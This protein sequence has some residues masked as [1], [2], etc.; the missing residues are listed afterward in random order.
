LLGGAGSGKAAR[1]S[2]LGQTL[3]SE[4]ADRLR[5]DW[6]DS[7][8]V[9]A[10]VILQQVNLA[11]PTAPCRQGGPGS[12]H[13]CQVRAGIR[14]CGILP[15]VR[16]TNFFRKV[17]PRPV[18]DAL[19]P[20]L[21]LYRE[22][23]LEAQRAQAVEA[24]TPLRQGTQGQTYEPVLWDETPSAAIRPRMCEV[25]P[26]SAEFQRILNQR[27]YYS[28]E[29]KPGLYTRGDE[30]V[31]V[32]C[33][34][35][36]LARM[37]PLGL[38]ACDIGTM[39]GMIPVLLKRRG[40]RSVVALDA[41][42]HTEK[43]RLVQL[44]TGENFDYVPRNS[45]ARIKEVLSERARLSSYYGDEWNQTKIQTGFDVVVLSG[46]LYHTISP[47]HV[48]GLAR[49]L[50]KRGGMLFLETAASC[51]D[52]YTQNWV[53][54]G[55]K[56]IYPGGSNTWFPT[57]KLLDHF[58]R[59][60]K[61]KPID[62]VHGPI[63]DGIVRIAVSAVSVADPLPLERESEWFMQTTTNT[64]DYREIVDTEWSQGSSVEIPYSPGKCVY[65]PG[66]SGVVDLHLTVM[67]QPALPNDRNRVILRL[68]DKT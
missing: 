10:I 22:R 27:W 47:L 23:R 3:S 66:L 36:L 56:W 40:A 54:R 8:D 30:H 57:L 34:R 32:I 4:L 31:N 55:D 28:V 9:R 26:N 1:T 12:Q 14:L 18:R 38:D 29:L 44:C 33:T 39:E 53:F 68:E 48:I 59:F 58:L 51:Q 41:M 24:V 60:M 11:R 49:T 16:V 62:C 64:L 15:N 35:E 46:V 19:R 45:L 17:L 5:N 13:S 37:S 67:G 52:Q 61:F 7:G 42:D 2:P 43:V 20:Y 6:P 63:N 65:H 50:L 25:D 21:V